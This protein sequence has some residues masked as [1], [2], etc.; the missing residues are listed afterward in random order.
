MTDIPLREGAEQL[1]P[2]HASLAFGVPRSDPGTIYALSVTGG[3]RFTAREERTVVFGRNRPDVH[4][5]VGEDD[6]RISR[7][8][9]TVTYRSGRWWLANTGHRALQLPRSMTL[10]PEDDPYPVEPGY[11]PVFVNG[12]AR[13]RH[14]L[15]LYVADDDGR[16]PRPAPD[17]ETLRDK[18]W[19]LRAD[20]RLA[21]VSLAQKYLLHEAYPQPCTW[22]Q[23]AQDLVALQPGEPWTAKRVEHLVSGVRKRLSRAGVP[24]LTREEV[25]E[26]VGNMLNHNLVTELLQT[27]TLVPPDVLLLEEL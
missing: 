8:Q 18:P 16:L 2:Q 5:C 13:R 17:A 15:E 6:L 10:F 26:P 3:V 9:G 1:S 25:G 11:T 12:T 14:L 27:R 21:L 7:N 22:Q 23:V 4:V 24:G 19:K 20:E